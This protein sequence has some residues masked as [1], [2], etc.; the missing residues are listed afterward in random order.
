MTGSAWIGDTQ[1]NWRRG[2]QEQPPKGQKA[3]RAGSNPAPCQP[4]VRRGEPM[5]VGRI[6]FGINDSAGNGRTGKILLNWLNGTL[7]NPIFP[8]ADFWGR[9]IQNP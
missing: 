7:L 9:P 5:T 8:P 3:P 2:G 6:T 4:Q 1:R